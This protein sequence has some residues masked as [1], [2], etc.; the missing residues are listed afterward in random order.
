MMTLE[1]TR[2][3]FGINDRTMRILSKEL[4]SLDRTNGAYRKSVSKTYYIYDPEAR[5]TKQ[6]EIWN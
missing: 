1:E 5:K 2:K 3:M 4:T 6:V